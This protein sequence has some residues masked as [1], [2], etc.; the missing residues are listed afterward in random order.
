MSSALEKNKIYI[1]PIHFWMCRPEVQPALP[2]GFGQLSWQVLKQ[3]GGQSASPV[4]G[5]EW[6][7]MNPAIFM[8]SMN[9]LFQQRGACSSSHKLFFEKTYSMPFNAH[10]LTECLSYYQVLLF[11][12]K[13]HL[14]YFDSAPKNR[15]FKDI[16]DTI[17][18]ETQTLNL[19]I[20]KLCAIELCNTSM[21]GTAASVEQ[22]DFRRKQQSKKENPGKSKIS[23]LR[24]IKIWPLFSKIK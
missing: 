12:F 2:H 8:N 10:L 9:R 23:N 18:S 5:I 3:A 7:W 19:L 4:V 1:F 11:P 13:I 24:K 22:N 6:H 16:W 20:A 17:F 21:T 14:P 15:H